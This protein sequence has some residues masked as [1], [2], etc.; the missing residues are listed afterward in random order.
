MSPLYNALRL[1]EGG[2][3]WGAAG[4]QRVLGRW[5]L[6]LGLGVRGQKPG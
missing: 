1:Q 3:T 4:G 6:G 2:A 5:G